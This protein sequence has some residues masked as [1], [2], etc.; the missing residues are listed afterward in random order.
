MDESYWRHRSEEV[1]GIAE[2]LKTSPAKRDMYVIAAAYARLARFARKGSGLSEID[3]SVSS[4][5]DPTAKFK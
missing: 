2:T 3:D 5:K 4:K 1:R